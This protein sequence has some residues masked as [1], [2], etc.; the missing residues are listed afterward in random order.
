MIITNCSTRS[1]P[2]ENLK[3][4]TKSKAACPF[5]LRSTQSFRP[6]PFP[7]PFPFPRALQNKAL[8]LLQ[9][10]SY[11]SQSQRQSIRDNL[12]LKSCRSPFWMSLS[13]ERELAKAGTNSFGPDLQ[14]NPTQPNPDPPKSNRTSIP[15]A[16]LTDDPSLACPST[17]SPLRHCNH[18]FLPPNALQA[19]LA[20][21]APTTTQP[22][23]HT[24]SRLSL[25]TRSIALR[26]SNRR[27]SICLIR[28]VDRFYRSGRSLDWA[29]NHQSWPFCSNRRK[30]R[31]TMHCPRRTGTF[32]LRKVP[33][34]QFQPSMVSRTK[35][36]QAG[37]F[38]RHQAAASTTL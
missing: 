22:P 20:S 18:T 31:A 35:R 27:D 38:R 15:V 11:N 26:I 2:L 21:Y 19:E 4:P 32:T 7:F 28:L 34:H 17:L 13:Q 3:Q 12:N 33:S 29:S 6:I 8:F 14:T 16:T 24:R 36:D 5:A 37:R 25:S 1:C 23:G 30:I 10:Y 9:E